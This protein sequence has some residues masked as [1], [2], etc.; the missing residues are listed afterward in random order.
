MSFLEEL[1]SD[2][3]VDLME[4][5]SREM[6]LAYQR[7]G[8]SIIF[9]QGNRTIVIEHRKEQVGDDERSRERHWMRISTRFVRRDGFT[10]KFYRDGI[11]SSIGRLFGMQDIKTGDPQFDDEFIIKGN[12][13]SRVRLLLSNEKLKQIIQYSPDIH[14]EC[15]QVGNSPNRDFELFLEM[16]CEGLDFRKFRRAVTLVTEVLDEL[17]RSDRAGPEKSQI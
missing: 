10:F 13:E 14:L 12:D 16:R 5:F 11:L 1:F 9:R 6:G 7:E 2:G 17:H 3:D 15:R 8:S 4:Q